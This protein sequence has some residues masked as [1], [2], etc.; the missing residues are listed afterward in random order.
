MMCTSETG[1]LTTSS[2]SFGVD[3]SGV[4]SRPAGRRSSPSAPVASGPS[5]SSSAPPRMPVPSCSARGDVRG[6]ANSCVITLLPW[7]PGGVHI[8]P[9][10][11]R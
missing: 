1:T 8:P 6:D 10:A 2:S 11:P 5:S 7:W 3:A 9:P 4:R